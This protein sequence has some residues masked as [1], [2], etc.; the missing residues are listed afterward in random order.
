V[1]GD[2]V[3]NGWTGRT[4]SLWVN[5]RST[6]T[7]GWTNNSSHSLFFKIGVLQL[8]IQKNASGQLRLVARHG[9]GVSFG[10]DVLSTLAIPLDRWVHLATVHQGTTVTLYVDGQP[11]GTGSTA[12]TIGA[13]SVERLFIVGHAGS[14]S[15]LID[16]LAFYARALSA[17]EVQQLRQ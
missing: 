10:T 1:T 5:L 17:A 2:Q 7:A 16:D 8:R 4:T 15:G 14:F 13:A 6:V 9:D 11:A 3:F 12:R